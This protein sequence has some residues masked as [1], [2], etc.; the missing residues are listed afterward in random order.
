MDIM[1]VVDWA[2]RVLVVVV[3]DVDVVAGRDGAKDG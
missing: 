2:V 1:V 3:V